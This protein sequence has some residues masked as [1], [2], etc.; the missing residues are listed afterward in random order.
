MKGNRF[1]LSSTTFTP[2]MYLSQV[3][4]DAS[5]KDL[6]QGL[7]FLSRSID[8]KSA[9]LKVLV[10]S[11]FERFV[12]AKSVIDNVYTEMRNQ[13]IEAIAPEKARPHSR[14]TS[15]T[16]VHFRNTS[17]GQNGFGPSRTSLRPIINEKRKHALTKESEYGVQGIKAPLIEVAV[18]AEEIWGPALGG[19]ERENNLKSILESIDRSH[20]VLQVGQLIEDSIKRKDY[21]SLVKDYQ[22]AR[23]LADAAKSMAVNAAANSQQ[24]TDAQIHQIVI[25]ARM[26]L[27]VEAQIEDFK[28]TIWRDLTSV[29]ANLTMSTDRNHQEDHVALISVLLELGVED[30]P[31]W[32]WLL[33]RYDYLKNK[34]TSTF[35]RSRIEIEVLRRQLAS[36]DKPSIYSSA[37]HFK[38]LSHS[39]AEDKIKHLDTGPTLE[40]WDL[41]VHAMGNLLSMQGGVLG[42]VIDFWDKAQSFIK[43]EAQRTLPIGIDGDSQKH[44]RLSTDGVGALQNGAMELVDILREH[45]F[46][47][48]ADPPIEDVS[49][50][51]SPDTTDTPNTP[52]TPRSATLSPFS[53][54]DQRFNLDLLSPPPPSPKRGEAWE[55]FA[56]WPPYSNSLSGVH[57]LSKLLVLLGTAA[58]E[59]AAIQPVTSTTNSIEKLKIFINAARERSAKAICAAWNKDVQSCQ[60]LE[61]WTRGPGTLDVTRMPSYF[62]TFERF[63]LSGVQKILYI[64]EAAAARRV[65]SEIVTPP[66]AKLLQMIRSQF[67][68]SLAKALLGMAENAEKPVNVGQNPWAMD[69]DVPPAN[70]SETALLTDT[71]RDVVDA[72]KK[73]RSLPPLLPLDLQSKLF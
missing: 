68:G 16:S 39:S 2:T 47:F 71:G 31:I 1:L 36:E 65:A 14:H 4:S 29:Q 63:I 38:S 26:W 13:G 62:A 72:S 48:F 41:I 18:K 24:P 60:V 6:I 34:I 3:H 20:N 12:K 55:D 45:I 40:L 50:L 27:E 23:E 10:E 70:K 61:D 53:K 17:G 11:N 21:N 42:E 51:F 54:P 44:H 32:V 59:M 5:T 30:N 58:A 8:K 35:E 28:R 9:S 64:P 37:I 57:Y 19:R 33:S 66:P 67:V 15:R 25:T 22:K 43:G 69:L 49:A 46:S 56:F 7:E 73:V 52:R